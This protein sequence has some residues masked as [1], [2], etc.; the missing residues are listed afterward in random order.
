MYIVLC[1]Y[2][3]S[4]G[5]FKSQEVAKAVLI[6]KKNCYRNSGVTTVLAVVPFFAS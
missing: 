2:N 4:Y 3:S 6:Y 5:T 1:E